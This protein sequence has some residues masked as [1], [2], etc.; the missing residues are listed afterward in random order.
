MLALKLS[1]FADARRA[2]RR[3]DSYRPPGSS[4]CGSLI[5]PAG[6]QYALLDFFAAC[7]KVRMREMASDEESHLVA[8]LQ[9]FA[10]RL[11][12]MLE[13]DLLAIDYSGAPFKERLAPMDI[14]TNWFAHSYNHCNLPSSQPMLAFMLFEYV[15]VIGRFCFIAND[16][17]KE[18]IDAELVAVRQTTAQM[19]HMAYAMRMQWK[20]LPD[21]ATY[22]FQP[23]ADLLKH[24]G[25]VALVGPDYAFRAD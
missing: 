12:R 21:V 25:T 9:L 23:L 13:F 7:P 10:L 15:G 19:L 11:E 1:S 17:S 22:F 18:A 4:E 24:R 2:A 16:G 14:E 8:S 5:G 20:R 6:V 3:M